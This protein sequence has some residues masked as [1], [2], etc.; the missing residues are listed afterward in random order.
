MNQN[1]LITDVFE[2]NPDRNLLNPPKAGDPKF[3]EEEGNAYFT[4]TYFDHDR[5]HQ[6][7]NSINIPKASIP[8]TVFDRINAP[9]FIS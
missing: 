9:A 2:K 5:Q 1:L 6:Y 8:S 7:N 4:K 3:V